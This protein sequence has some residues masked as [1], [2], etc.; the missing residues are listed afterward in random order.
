MFSNPPI[1][2]DF[3]CPIP[4][5]HSQTDLNSVLNIFHRWNCQQMA[6]FQQ[7]GKWG[8]IDSVDLLSLITEVHLDRETVASG[9][10][11]SLMPQQIGL[12]SRA[13]L[14]AKQAT[15][16]QSDMRLDEFFNGLPEGSLGCDGQKYLLVDKSGELQGKLDKNKVLEYLASEYKSNWANSCPTLVKSGYC[17]D[18]I[19][20]IDLPLK[21]ETTSGEDL[22]FNSCWQE[23]IM[24]DRTQQ[25]R[26]SKSAIAS[27]RSQQQLDTLDRDSI[28]KTQC[29]A[30]NYLSACLS[31]L[32][33]SRSSGSVQKP[34]SSTR[35]IST[36][37]DLKA[38][39][40]L[41]D[42]KQNQGSKFTR[43]RLK[44]Q[45]IDRWNY[46]T[47]PLTDA[48]KEYQLVLALEAD[49]SASLPK[50]I[51]EGLLATVTHELKSP[52][53]GIVGLSSLL[54]AQLGPLNQRQTRYL[55]LI[56]SSGQ[57]MM[58]IV[59][60]LIKLST[61]TENSIDSCSI[62][63]EVLCR[64]VYQQ[65]LKAIQSSNT[66]DLKISNS[67]R[68]DLEL[69]SNGI[70]IASKSHLSC[71][72]LHL[73][74]EVVDAKSPERLKIEISSLDGA[75]AIKISSITKP[76][77]S[78]SNYNINSSLRLA[79]VEYLIELIQADLKS[80]L[81]LNRCQFTLLL[82]TVQS[83]RISA[84]PATVNT[85]VTETAKSNLTILCLYPE[86]EAIGDRADDR[87]GL[88]FDLKSWQD[89][90]R[91]SSNYQHRII[92]ADGLEQAH[93][94]ARIWQLDVIVLYGHQLSNRIEYLQL[95][96]TSEYLSALPLVTLDN[97]TTQAANQIKGLN[98]YPCLLP[99][100][101]RRVE[102]LMQ[103]IQIAAGV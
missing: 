78:S 49:S 56:H 11:T 75:I 80:D 62:D 36:E 19:D 9:R 16:Y 29:T 81:S 51:V 34:A 58:G 87:N 64:Q 66:S 79:M 35:E 86:A 69:E 21:I 42:E 84:Q 70:A 7:N 24:G 22:Y 2:S 61:L 103:V 20:S 6:I 91:H 93:T 92:E 8:L 43:P 25:K 45:Q 83:D 73:M 3:V 76:P 28:T 33:L 1:L 30:E 26:Q 96:Q 72:L 46:V 99:A 102:D 37:L 95:L 94:L 15:V 50:S 65:L 98:V 13:C 10:F 57:K 32:S 67:D 90:S 14:I 41:A 77:S 74:M 44:I 89:A 85:I 59:N 4:Y 53:T 48:N 31:V 101:H 23:L 68:L 12:N 97:K 18:L 82:P 52:L 55:E 88:S 100:E 54:A 17:L 40:N 38:E 27:W 71:I 63:L 47:I 5:C 39:A 60:D